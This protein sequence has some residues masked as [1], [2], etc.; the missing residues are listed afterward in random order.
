MKKEETEKGLYRGEERKGEGEGEGD[1]RDTWQSV[2]CCWN[3]QRD[4]TV[5]N[6]YEASSG[7]CEQL[8]IWNTQISSLCRRKEFFLKR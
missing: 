1:G 5:H 2:I 6:N 8:S 4:M 3:V 7:K